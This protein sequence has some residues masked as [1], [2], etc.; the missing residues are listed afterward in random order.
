MY[1]KRGFESFFDLAGSFGARFLCEVHEEKRDEFGDESFLI[2]SELVRVD[3]VG[4]LLVCEVL[5][6]GP[7]LLTHSYWVKCDLKFC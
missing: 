2:L 5:G 4:S 3:S 7:I 6:L 1:D